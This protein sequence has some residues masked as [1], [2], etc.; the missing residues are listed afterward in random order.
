MNIVLE[1]SIIIE[2]WDK[3]HKKNGRLQLKLTY[4]I[5]F[6]Q[7]CIFPA[8]K[9]F[10]FIYRSRLSFQ[11]KLLLSDSV[12]FFITYSCCFILVLSI[13]QSN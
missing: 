11:E 1:E 10:K 13:F 9:Y 8:K 6:E 2:V 3:F 5:N 12:I 7:T 4:R